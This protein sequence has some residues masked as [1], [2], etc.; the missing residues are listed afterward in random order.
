VI[1]TSNKTSGDVQ[2]QHLQ[3]SQV[4]TVAALC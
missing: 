4:K 1:I 3:E 2:L